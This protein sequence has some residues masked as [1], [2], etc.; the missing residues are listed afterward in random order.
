MGTFVRQVRLQS[1][2]P[3]EVNSW[4]DRLA[5]NGTVAGLPGTETDINKRWTFEAATQR[6]H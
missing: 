5:V 3:L 1:V 2:Q 4:R 6:G